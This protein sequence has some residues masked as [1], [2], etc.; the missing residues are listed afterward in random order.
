MLHDPYTE[1][2]SFLKLPQLMQAKLKSGVSLKLSPDTRAAHPSLIMM[3]ATH[4]FELNL[5]SEEGRGLALAFAL[6]LTGTPP[7]A[8]CIVTELKRVG[9]LY[10]RS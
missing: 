3:S 8:L 5:F 7:T 6:R 1:L 2:R 4:D 10:S 9:D